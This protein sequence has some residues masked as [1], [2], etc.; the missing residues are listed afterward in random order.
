M[1]HEAKYYL[2]Q[3]V[4]LIR[5]LLTPRAEDPIGLMREQLECRESRFLDT[6]NRIVF[7]NPTHPFNTMFRLADYT[8]DKV[9]KLVAEHGLETT[10]DKLYSSGIYI[11]DPELKGHCTIVRQGVEIPSDCD[12]FVNPL[13]SGGLV[14]SSSGSRG[15]AMR[16]QKSTQL[17]IYREA[18]NML[19]F[20]EFDLLNTIQV[21]VLPI[22]PSLSGLGFAVREA[23]RGSNLERWFSVGGTMR[24]SGHY[25]TFTRFLVWL[26]NLLGTRVIGPTYLPNN[27]FMPVAEYIARR[28]QDGK[29]C[30]LRGPVSQVT[31]VASVALSTGLDLSGV[32]VLVGGEVLTSTK[33][34]VIESTGARVFPAYGM[35]ELGAIG[36][37]CSQMTTGNSVHFR[38][39]SLAL[40]T[41]PYLSSDAGSQT[42]LL[43]FTTLLPFTP[44]FLINAEMRETGVIKKAECDCA[45][46]RLGLNQ[47]ITNIVPVSK[48]TV[49]GM[50]LLVSDLAKI[51]EEM[52]PARFGGNPGDYQLVEREAVD[53]SYV[54]LRI[55]A[56]V[57][58]DPSNVKEYFLKT[59]GCIV[60]GS[61]A[62]RHWR[63]A[64]AIAVLLAEPLETHTGKIHSVRL[65]RYEEAAQSE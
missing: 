57:V 2:R 8:F 22:L 3:S 53:Q 5:L 21:V 50:T 19:E 43:I 38:K 10:L 52:L 29:R 12:S 27:D 6:L 39:D 16:T 26:A 41:R 24:D 46:T 63:H 36:R 37:A 55:S 1:I 23:R 44:L 47:L 25:R 42:S 64:D 60:G 59:L 17:K 15:K 13:F 18:A 54:E 35:H 4:G 56:R 20:R 61:L 65:L 40:V 28:Q 11:T 49:Q 45:F 32:I 30:V 33:R 58:C 51:L 62:A 34:Q 7:S 9:V 48:V 14:S 31:R